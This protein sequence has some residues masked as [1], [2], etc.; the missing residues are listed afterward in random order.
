VILIVGASG[1][2]GRAVATSLLARGEAVRLLAR[3]P[4]KVD[5]LRQAGAEVVPGD[6]ID[7]ASLTAACR[8]VRQVFAA[9]HGFIG[10]GP[11]AS[12]HVD[13]TGH[14]ALIDSAKAADVSHVVYTSALGA[15]PD[16]PVDFFRTKYKIEKYLEASGMSYTILRP[17]AFMETHAHTFNGKSVLE[18]GKTSILG[19]GTKPRNFV[20]VRDVAQ[21]AVIALTDPSSLNRVLSVGG[22]DNLSNNEVA[23][24]YGRLA[25]ITPKVDHM[26]AGIARLLSIVMKPFH[27]GVSRIMYI[28]SLPDDAYDER[29]DVASL[30]SE[31]SLRLTSLEDFVRGRVVESKSG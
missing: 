6:L 31:Y 8:G 5:A 14:R 23:E 4:A 13:D 30:P 3:T 18:R 27:P 28:G 11:Y 9:A 2:L 12:E 16:H 10:R 29:F 20:A 17:S 25:G 22:P 24:T 21:L 26:P 1:L 7:P 15:A 19:P